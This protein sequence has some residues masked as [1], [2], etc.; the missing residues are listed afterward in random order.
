MSRNLKIAALV[1]LVVIIGGGAF[2]FYLFS[3]KQADLSN[4]K[5]DFVISATELQ[6]EFEENESMATEKFTGKIVETSGE[7]ISIIG[8]EN[9]SLTVTLQTGSDLSKVICTFIAGSVPADFELGK[10]STVRG[11]CSGFLMDVLLNNCVI[12][13]AK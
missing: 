7:V 2:G 5:P 4:V 8:S 9:G 11:E 1:L 13:H 12:V 10:E 6:K 3:K